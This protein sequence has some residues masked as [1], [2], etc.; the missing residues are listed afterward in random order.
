MGRVITL[1]SFKGGCGKTTTS[2]GLCA[3]AS[4]RGLSVV[5]IDL[6]PSMGTSRV[7]GVDGSPLSILSVANGARTL[8]CL[9]GSQ[10]VLEGDGGAVRVLRSD[11]QLSRFPLATEVLV[12]IV[13][14]CAAVADLVVIDTQNAE[15]CMVGPLAAA[16]IGIVP[17]TPTE[18]LSF[19][20]AM[21][22][23]GLADA[24]G[25]LDRVGGVLFT[26]V[27]S[28]TNVVD[29]T[30]VEWLR[31]TMG[32]A[33]RTTMTWSVAWKRMLKGE[34]LRGAALESA[35][36]LLDEAW[37]WRAPVEQLRAVA[38]PYD[39]EVVVAPLPEVYA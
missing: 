22:A 16:D 37:E 10:G 15:A 36:A 39:P 18:P 33:Y 8:E 28:Q 6:D 13:G 38:D 26:Q 3:A 7:L 29:R 21:R 9:V 5:A 31:D 1:V 24:A 27:P 12:N 4:S 17:T 20:E 19:G 32:V 35:M 30:A 2:V 23:L 34:P 25:L 14:E 11:P